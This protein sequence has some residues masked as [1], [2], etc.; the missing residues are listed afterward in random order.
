[1]SSQDGLRKVQGL[2][3]DDNA[4]WLIRY[5]D[6]S[7]QN[8]NIESTAIHCCVTEKPENKGL[9]RGFMQTLENV[10]F[11]MRFCTHMKLICCWS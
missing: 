5:H 9:D 3:H 6:L 11:L 4:L 8:P 7:K 1:M 10:I 2:P